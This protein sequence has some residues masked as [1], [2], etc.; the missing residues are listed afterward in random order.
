MTTTSKDLY[1]TDWQDLVFCV[2]DHLNNFSQ[3]QVKITLRGKPHLVVSCVD[4]ILVL[5]S[6]PN[7]SIETVEQN[8]L[9]IFP[10]PTNNT[11]TVELDLE[12][13]GNLSIT[14]TDLQGRELFEIY[15]GFTVEGTFS[16]TFSMAMLP[17]GVYYL[18]VEHNGG[19]TVEKVVRE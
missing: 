7:V 9:K 6:D 1:R 4:D 17:V 18:R 5:T 2:N 16:K 3:L 8:S 15:S 10:N 11:A 13:A 12:S 14:L 19:V